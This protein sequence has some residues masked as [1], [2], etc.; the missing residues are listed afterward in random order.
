MAPL[1][2]ENAPL[3]MAPLE[4][5]PLLEV[6]MAFLESGSRKLR[7]SGIRKSEELSGD[8]DIGIWSQNGSSGDGDEMT[9]SGHKLQ[10]NFGPKWLSAI[11][12]LALQLH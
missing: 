12:A 7:S 8:P 9:R 3:A 6:A 10:L 4:N 11:L 1:E 5:N 2:A